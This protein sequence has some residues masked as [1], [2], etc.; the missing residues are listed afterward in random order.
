MN[1][2]PAC[3]APNLT[4]RELGVLRAIADGKT[5]QQIAD[6][7]FV[8]EDTVDSAAG[9]V[10]RKLDARNA[11]HAVHIAHQHGL[12]GGPSTAAS[13]PVEARHG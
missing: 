10:Y 12:L 9:R 1:V 6:E 4:D 8:A 3:G 7:Q 13:T 5:Y 2:C 11:A